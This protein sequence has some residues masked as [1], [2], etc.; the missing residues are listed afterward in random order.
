LYPQVARQGG[1]LTPCYR[2]DMVA[3]CNL[4]SKRR[5][6]RPRPP[7]EFPKPA[8]E[9]KVPK[10]APRLPPGYD[11]TQVLPGLFKSLGTVTSVIKGG[12]C[13]DEERLESSTFIS[14]TDAKLF[15]LRCQPDRTGNTSR[16][17]HLNQVFPTLVL[18]YVTFIS[19][20][21]G[22]ST[23]KF[24]SRFQEI[25]YNETVAFGNVIMNIFRLLLS[26]VA[27][28]SETFTVEMASLI[29]AC[30]KMDWLAMR[31]V[32]VALFD[33]LVRDPACKGQLQDLWKNRVP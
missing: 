11:M 15:N 4:V 3:A 2:L 21:E 24:L 16:R 18:I 28:E 13:T 10:T 25:F 5:F 1:P 23:S 20:H 31:D 27:F 8:S 32:K 33:F 22:Q 6:S 9:V 12:S 19:G 7:A 14:E 17:H 29:E 30:T 26:H